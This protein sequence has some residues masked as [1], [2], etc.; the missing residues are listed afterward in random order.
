MSLGK[1]GQPPTPALTAIARPSMVRNSREYLTV[2]PIPHS[3]PTA[4]RFMFAVASASHDPVRY[5][6][7]IHVFVCEHRVS[8]PD[9]LFLCCL[10]SRPAFPFLLNDLRSK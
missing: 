10:L 1:F 5:I 8:R 9:I 6:P 3:S 7:V 2:A 4:R